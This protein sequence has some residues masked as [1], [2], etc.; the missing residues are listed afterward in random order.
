MLIENCKS[1]LVAI[2]ND[3]RSLARQNKQKAEELE[4]KRKREEKQQRQE[5]FRRKEKRYEA[6]SI[7]YYWVRF[8]LKVSVLKSDFQEWKAVF[9]VCNTLYEE[10]S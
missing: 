9:A 1:F 5:E 3:S 10:Q 8:F 2:Y 6:T 7:S 4:R